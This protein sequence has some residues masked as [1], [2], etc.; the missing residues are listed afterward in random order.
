MQASWAAQELHTVRLGDK[1]LHARLF[2]I[3]DALAKRPQASIPE[4]FGTWTDTKAFYRFCSSDNVDAHDIARAHRKQTVERACQHSRI[5]AIQ[6]TT[7][8]DFTGHRAATGLGPINATDQQ[9][10]K[11]HS[12]LAAT[13][14]GVPLGL[15]ADYVWSRDPKK[16]GQSRDWRKRPLTDKETL[17][18]YFGLSDSHSFVPESVQV[19]CICDRQ[20]DCFELFSAPRPNH[21]HLLVRAAYDRRVDVPGQKLFATLQAAP[22]AGVQSLHL[23]SHP[24]R[25]EREVQLSVRFASVCLQPPSYRPELVPVQVQAVLAQEQNPPVGVKPLRW[26]LLST[27]PVQTFAEACQMLDWYAHR[28]LIERYHFVLKSGC[29]LERLQLATR[30]RLQVALSLYSLVAWRLLFLTYQARQQPDQSCEPFLA[31]A[32]WQALFCQVHRT[33]IAPAS[34]PTLRQA[35]FWIAGLGGFLGRKGDGQPGVQ[36][37]WRGLQRLH[38]LTAMWQLLHGPNCG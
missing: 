33:P 18:W 21:S 23:R 35:V 19:I 25:P 4:A 17:Y 2:A 20:G 36:V 16:R 11:L 38:D 22:L 9:G 30:A 28:W 7:D 29:H 6:D 15:L 34:A 3:L 37:L 14:T 12:V 31:R 32:E 10:F 8:F 26:L 27:C 1:R 13:D 5:L 24:L